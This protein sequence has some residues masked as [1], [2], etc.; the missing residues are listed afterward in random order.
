MPSM[1]VALVALN[2]IYFFSISTLFGTLMWIFAV[3][4][5]IGSVYSGFHYAADGIASLALMPLIWW[6]AGRLAN[7][8]AK[9]P[10]RQPGKTSVE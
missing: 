4:I 2:A 9:G 8:Q 6:A 10:S 3:I 5:L 7:I 1:H